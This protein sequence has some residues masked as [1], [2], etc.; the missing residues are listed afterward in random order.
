[1]RKELKEK[2]KRY[3]ENIS[4]IIKGTNKPKRQK[5]YFIRLGLS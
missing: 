2:F 4:G 3:A 5:E 1:M